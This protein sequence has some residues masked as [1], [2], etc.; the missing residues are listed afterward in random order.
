MKLER[1]SKLAIGRAAGFESAMGLRASFG[2]NSS[3]DT[4]SFSAESLLSTPIGMPV[5]LAQPVWSY[6]LKQ[7]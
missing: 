6:G 7:R 2:L 3:P 5:M 1:H 4:P